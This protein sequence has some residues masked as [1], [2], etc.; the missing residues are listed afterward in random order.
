MREVAAYDSC[1]NHSYE[2]NLQ[3]KSEFIYF[4]M[5]SVRAHGELY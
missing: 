3:F 2:L 1:T 5:F 4:L